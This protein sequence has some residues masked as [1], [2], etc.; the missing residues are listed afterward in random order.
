MPCISTD[1]MACHPHQ[2]NSIAQFGNPCYAIGLHEASLKS[3][4]AYMLLRCLDSQVSQPPVP[5][6][7]A[8][9]LATLQLQAVLNRCKRMF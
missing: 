2:C 4:F 9:G 8:G 7:I 3:Q 1:A 6:S 5:K